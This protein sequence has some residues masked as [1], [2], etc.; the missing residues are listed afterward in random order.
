[1]EKE[2]SQ[3]KFTWKMAVKLCANLVG[4]FAVSLQRSIRNLRCI[5]EML[6]DGT[7]KEH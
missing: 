6:R 4:R 1:M 2:T 3:P 7:E 5:N